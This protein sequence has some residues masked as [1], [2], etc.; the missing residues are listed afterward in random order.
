MSARATFWA[1]RV[2]QS[3]SLSSTERLVLLRLGDG[4]SEETGEC[5]YKQESIAKVTGL[6]RSGVQKALYALAEHGLVLVERVT[7]EGRTLANTYRLVLDLEHPLL[8][9]DAAVPQSEGMPTRKAAVASHVSSIDPALSDPDLGSG[10]S[11]RVRRR[12]SFEDGFNEFWKIYPRKIA[13]EAALKAWVK[14]K[15]ERALPSIQKLAETLEEHAQILHWR[16]KPDAIPYPASWINGKRWND[17]AKAKWAPSIPKPVS[18]PADLAA[19]DLKAAL[20]N[21]RNEID[22][23]IAPASDG[24]NGLSR[25]AL[26]D[27]LDACKSEAEV[28][29]HLAR[30]R[31][32]CDRLRAMGAFPLRRPT[33]PGEILPAGSGEAWL[34][35]VNPVAVRP[36]PGTLQRAQFSPDTPFAEA[37]EALSEEIKDNERNVCHHGT[38]YRYPCEECARADLENAVAFCMDESFGDGPT[39]LRRSVDCNAN[40]PAEKVVAAHE[41]LVD[42]GVLPAQTFDGPDRYLFKVD[43][44]PFTYGLGKEQCARCGQRKDAAVHNHGGKENNQFAEINIKEERLRDYRGQH[45]YAHNS[46]SGKCV[47]CGMPRDHIR[48]YMPVELPFTKGEN[49]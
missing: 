5:W 32:L 27:G 18:S 22:K 34:V 43:P 35:H 8:T 3:F 9:T 26:F 33:R 16:D 29:D 21:A 14:A 10:E 31:A 15:K 12:A 4:A 1:W 6:S 11:A 28:A 44:H 41:K 13:K 17:E 20:N 36:A 19:R 25:S 24:W 48:H 40:P 46:L 47:H 49:S 37:V 23:A 30:C 39:V 38:P 45:T 2:G 7:H 42:V